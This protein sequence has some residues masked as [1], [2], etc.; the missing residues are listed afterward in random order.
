MTDD[1]TAVVRQHWWTTVAS[2]TRLI[3]DLEAAED[4]AQDACV[5]ALRQW[6][7]A[8]VPEHPE[9]W[10]VSVAR[11]K[12][13]DAQRREAKRAE[14]EAAAVRDETR[15]SIESQAPA[16]VDDQLALIFMCCH[17]TLEPASQIALTL[18]A[19]CGLTTSEIARA[20]LTPEATVAQRLVR[21]KRK[22]RE[23]V[24]PFRTPDGDGLAVR[25]AAVLRIVYLVFTEGHRSNASQAGTRP[26]LCR[27]AI[28][29]ASSLA[30]M[31]PGEPEVRGL[32]ALL[33]LVDARRPGRFD[34]EG[35]LVLLDEQDRSL[36]DAAKIAEGEAHLAS[37]L[38]L[39]RPGPYQIQAAIAALH[40]TASTAA[41]TDWAEVAALYAELVRWEPTAVVE[42]NRA[43][44]VA[45]AHGPTAGLTIL[46]RLTDDPR[47][48]AWPPFHIARADLFS[49]LGLIER[50]AEAY[51]KA[52]SLSPPVPER[53]FINRR[54]GELARRGLGPGAE[55]R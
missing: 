36:W 1:L 32:L 26:E 42:A 15:S 51:E 40:S 11:K 30:T 54:L 47:L 39:G 2:V 5:A 48:E 7:Q 55:K 12:A 3:G 4:A 25:L 19:V 46:D 20:F 13:L 14:K 43:V 49:R 34:A 23:A 18:R 27:E 16:M 31:M 45:M 17:P 33:L 37:A 24:I 8:R 52:L 21:A 6:R 28:H 29:L 9:R 38:S 41:A 10:L 44:A 35:Q 50:A 22:I 53:T